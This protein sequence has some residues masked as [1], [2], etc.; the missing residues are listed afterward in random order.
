MFRATSTKH[1]GSATRSLPPGVVD[2]LRGDGARG[3]EVWAF[4]GWD[5]Q[6]RE[7]PYR[8]LRSEEGLVRPRALRASAWAGR[9]VQVRGGGGGGGN[10]RGEGE[11]E[12]CAGSRAEGT[13]RDDAGG[14]DLQNNNDVNDTF[15]FGGWQQRTTA[16]IFRV[17]RRIKAAFG[18]G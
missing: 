17:W 6:G 9:G 5:A 10:D 13:M 15:S 11:A 18:D 4:A 12:V 16:A 14:S 2:S 1:F 7:L 8:R 3:G